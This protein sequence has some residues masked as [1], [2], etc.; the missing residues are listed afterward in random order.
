VKDDLGRMIVGREGREG[1]RKMSCMPM[2]NMRNIQ[3]KT[4]KPKE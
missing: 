1:G 4:L 3:F 2:R